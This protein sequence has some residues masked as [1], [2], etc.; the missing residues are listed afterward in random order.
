MADQSS[1][2]Y[3]LINDEPA[4]E[5]CPDCGAMTLCTF[6]LTAMN[7]EG[8]GDLESTMNRCLECHGEGNHER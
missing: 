7:G 5:E 3:I 6:T 2:E 1:T 4:I 8:V